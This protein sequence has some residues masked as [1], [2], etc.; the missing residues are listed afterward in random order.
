MAFENDI[1]NR[2]L[3]NKWTRKHPKTVNEVF[4]VVNSWADGELAEREQLD[5]FKH[6][7]E[8]ES[9]SRGK[10]IDRDSTGEK[11]HCDDRR[12]DN[13]YGHKRKSETDLVAAMNQ[14]KGRVTP[15][16][17][18]KMLDAQCPFHTQN[19]TARVY[20]ELRRAFNAGAG[21]P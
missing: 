21:R 15:E 13:K 10:R 8:E 19:H 6:R 12:S 1:I 3:I 2:A 14:A 4:A 7:W 11:D 20:F 17:F 18:Q 16:E 9:R 5:E